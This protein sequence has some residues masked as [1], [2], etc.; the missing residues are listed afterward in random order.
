[1]NETSPSNLR[2]SGSPL[3]GD[4]KEIRKI[5]PNLALRMSPER[6]FSPSRRGGSPMGSG[7]QFNGSGNFG[8]STPNLRSVRPP[9][10]AQEKSKLVD[11][12]TK[13][14]DV[15]GDLERQKTSLA[16][17]DDFN[18]EDAFRIFEVDGRGFLTEDDLSCGLDLL[19][20][21]HTPS[22]VRK[23]MKKY[24]NSKQGVLSYPDFF[25]IVTPY[26]KDLR[27]M[28]ENRP[29]NSCCPCKCP[30][31]FSCPTRINLKNLFESILDSERRINTERMGMSLVRAKLP[32]LFND[33]DRYGLGYFGEDDL[34]NYLQRNYAMG[35]DK[36]KDLLF[37]RM[38]KN[39]NGKIERYEV[40]DE[41][42]PQF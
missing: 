38:D 8:A 30:G 22:D 2:N 14:M 42:T 28:V 41:L 24:D 1:M 4:D 9:D 32:T 23:L 29:P 36:N 27:D 18:V 40:E 20:V 17:R 21:C 34:R 15:E 31:V 6:K 39:R 33:L 25:D 26:E 13:V 35:S 16:L 19:D 12:F 11:Y 10:D 3:R 7:S 5:S 37:I